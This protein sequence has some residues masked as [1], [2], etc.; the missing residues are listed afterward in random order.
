M[1]K[2]PDCGRENDDDVL[3]CIHCGAEIKKTS[4]TTKS[5]YGNLNPQTWLILFII[6]EIIGAIAIFMG[7]WIVGLPVIIAAG[8]LSFQ[9]GQEYIPRI[10]IL[11]AIMSLP[12]IEFIPENETISIF[13]FAIA[14]MSIIMLLPEES[15]RVTKGE[16]KEGRTNLFLKGKVLYWGLTGIISTIIWT[17]IILIFMLNLGDIIIIAIIS[18]ITGGMVGASVVWK[19]PLK[20]A[21]K[22][23]LTIVCFGPL[24]F[25]TIQFAFVT[26]G[27]WFGGLLS[28]VQHALSEEGGLGFSGTALDMILNPEL[29]VQAGLKP[30][31]TREITETSGPP[32]IAFTVSGESIPT[33]GCYNSS[34]FQIIGRVK[35]TGSEFIKDLDLRIKPEETNFLV[36]G[37][38][39]PCVNI[40][41]S[42]T[43]QEFKINS[44]PSGVTSSKSRVIERVPAPESWF[45]PGGDIRNAVLAALGQEEEEDILPTYSCYIDII[46]KTGYHSVARLPIQ[47]I[48][49]DYARN[50]FEQNQLSQSV[51]PGTVSAG[52]VEFS[53]GGFEQPVLYYKNEEN[54]VTMIT[55]ISNSGNGLID[56]Y[57]STYLYIPKKL[58]SKDKEVGSPQCI[59]RGSGDDWVCIDTFSKSKCE[60]L[61]NQYANDSCMEALEFRVNETI[62]DYEQFE[63]DSAHN[64]LDEGY[65]MCFYEGE[66]DPQ[67]LIT[68]GTCTLNVSNDIMTAEDLRQTLIIR[69]DVL[70]TYKVSS[71]ARITVRDCDV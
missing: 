56:D 43:N 37:I 47:F 8:Y 41:F 33:T 61:T 13:G 21:V 5:T 64:L 29:A 31:T 52:P 19:Q 66:V 6:M 53:L 68:T 54:H 28:D 67:K 65:A 39:T 4:L 20:P 60:D 57:L 26:G 44:L 27:A 14:W 24:L 17:V 71:D 34:S 23:I 7:F 36:E 48:E 10:T 70:Y 58:L 35:N 51:V 45:G 1:V 55:T 16:E 9:M 49:A 18:A 32:S 30:A 22:L 63:Y 15:G 11:I 62:N 59:N 38:L 40:E 12:M 69:G 25:F 3:F 2:C 46:A 50:K 42:S